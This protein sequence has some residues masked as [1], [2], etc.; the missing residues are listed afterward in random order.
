MRGESR[1]KRGWSETQTPHRTH[2][3]LSPYLV[4]QRA[5]SIQ[6]LKRSDERLGRRRVHKVKVDEIINAKRLE[7]ENLKV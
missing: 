4:V 3:S 7:K 1:G 5:E 6:L 2:G